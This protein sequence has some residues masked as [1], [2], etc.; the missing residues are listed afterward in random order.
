MSKS[1]LVLR[2]VL[3]GALLGVVCLFAP[4]EANAACTSS[5]L[6]GKWKFYMK[7]VDSSGSGGVALACTVNVD[8]GGS[9]A[10]G[11]NCRAFVPGGEGP[12]PVSGGG[13]AVS[14]NCKVTGTITFST[15]D[16]PIDG[17]WMAR[18][19]LKMSGTGVSCD[20][21]VIDFMAIKR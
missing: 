13:L 7:L 15:C 12:I 20:G 6:S 19:G 17:S 21:E 16:V 11:E 2:H 5:N 8:S 14:R 1:K 9:I 3:C 18:D 10:S 4:L